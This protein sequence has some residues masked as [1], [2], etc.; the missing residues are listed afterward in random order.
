MPLGPVP[1]PQ[2]GHTRPPCACSRCSSAYALRETPAL[3]SSISD[4]FCLMASILSIDVLAYRETR[5]RLLSG[6]GFLSFAFNI[7]LSRAGPQA[8]SRR[9]YSTYST[10][11]VLASAKKR[12]STC[13]NNAF[14]DFSISRVG[15][16]YFAGWSLLFRGLVP[17]VVPL[18]GRSVAKRLGL[19]GHFHNDAHFLSAVVFR[20]EL[21]N[22][23]LSFPTG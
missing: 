22:D 6:G 5:L 3:A 11:R 7:P 4:T 10:Y 12:A 14:S 17:F 15:P 2:H 8:R 18:F 19:M 20:L 9:V 16:F 1:L 13:G 21:G 23:S